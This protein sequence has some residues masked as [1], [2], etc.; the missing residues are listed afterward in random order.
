MIKI[1]REIFDD[2]NNFIMKF[3]SGHQ[4]IINNLEDL[5]EETSSV[6]LSKKSYG[7][8][9]GEIH[10]FQQTLLSHFE[11]QNTEFF[12]KLELFFQN[13]K[14]EF[15]MIEFLKKDLNEMKVEVFTFFEKHPCDMGDINPGS[16]SRDFS[17]LAHNLVV[18]IKIE[19][20]Y[21]FSL[22]EKLSV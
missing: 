4:D 22:L 9:K 16:F 18:R 13:E 3:R 21:L 19:E 12:Q 17:Q 15:K 7:K 6:N 1:S 10:I 20:E 11:K 2:E 5:K 14:Q 8:V